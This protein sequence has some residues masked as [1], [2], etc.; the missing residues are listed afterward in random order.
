MLNESKLGSLDA[1][2]LDWNS[3]QLGPI[4]LA[5]VVD[6]FSLS[7]LSVCDAEISRTGN[8]RFVRLFVMRA[9]A[10]GLILRQAQDH[11]G[12]M[13]RDFR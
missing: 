1:D 5:M 2:A 12:L 6:Q 4:L 7:N 13:A 9:C 10:G 3:V 8:L 11:G